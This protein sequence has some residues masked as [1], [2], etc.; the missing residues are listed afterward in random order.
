MSDKKQFHKFFIGISHENC[1]DTCT[2]DNCNTGAH[3][4]RKQ[5]YSCT[6]TRDSSGNDVGVGDSNCWEN[7]GS[8]ML[9]DCPSQG[10]FTFFESNYLTFLIKTKF[11]NK[12][13]ILIKFQDTITNKYSLSFFELSRFSSGG[14]T[15]KI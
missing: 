5:C 7:V 3:Q 11:L 15:D 4:I 8:N 12:F 2:E 9:V 6:A 1:K 13:R 14:Q 10:G